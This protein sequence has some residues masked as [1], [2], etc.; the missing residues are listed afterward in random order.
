MTLPQTKKI[1]LTETHIHGPDTTLE[2]VRAHDKDPRAWLA[3][4]P[5]CS[6]LQQFQIEHAGIMHAKAPYEV[7]RLSQSGSF[8]LV[9]ISGRGRIL[10]DKGWKDCLPGEACLLPAYATNA[11]HC[12][13]NEEWEF[14]WVRYHHPEGQVPLINST[15]PVVDKFEHEQFLSAIKGMITEASSM[16]R[17]AI[18]QQWVKLI[19]IYVSEFIAPFRSDERLWR[20]WSS[21]ESRL[22]EDWDLPQMAHEACMSTEHLRRLCRSQHG[23]SPIQQLRWLRMQRAAALLVT[24][25]YKIE[26]IAYDVGY[27]NPI[28]FSTAFKREFGVQPST[29]RADQAGIRRTAS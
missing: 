25:D 3:G 12:I 21:V 1:P 10:S 15:Q 4:Q 14:C 22:E 27:K 19:H 28:V 20:L 6:A 17:F 8:F 23:R 2:C 13:E 9:T 7:V 11:L 29:F 16:N 26:S 18:T 24:T 5:I